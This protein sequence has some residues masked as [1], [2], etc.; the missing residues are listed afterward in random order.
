MRYIRRGNENDNPNAFLYFAL[1]ILLIVFAGPAVL[2]TAI[3]SIVPFLNEGISCSRLQNGTGRAY[4]QSLIGRSVTTQSGEAP[5]S[6]G[7]RARHSGDS[8]VYTIVVYNRTLGTVPIVVRPDDLALGAN[9]LQ[10][11][12]GIMGGTGTPPNLPNVGLV[13]V[14]ENNIRLLGPRQRCV[15]QVR[16]SVSSVPPE[17]AI[18]NNL[19]RAFYRGNTVGQ[20]ERRMNSNQPVIFDTQGLWVGTVLSD[21]A[22]ISG[23][24]TQP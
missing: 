19:I 22:T 6:L 9:S 15:H 18:P 3:P 21:V 13:V 1:I 23:G 11:G 24:T 5:I 7:V 8:V 14:N 16:Y 10:D 2:P 4:H 12:L 20:A 17:L